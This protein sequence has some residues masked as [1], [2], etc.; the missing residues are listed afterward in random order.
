MLLISM[1]PLLLT[2]TALD[3]CD[4]GNKTVEENTGKLTAEY[5][6]VPRTRSN[7]DVSYYSTNDCNLTEACSTTS[8]EGN[9]MKATLALDVH[10]SKRM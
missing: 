9:I 6:L 2:G 4:E 5:S 1:Q 8:S 3:T 10:I 7:R